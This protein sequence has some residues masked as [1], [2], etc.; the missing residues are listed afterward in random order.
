MDLFYRQLGNGEN[1]TILHGLY[2]SSDN[3]N[4][5]SKL[6]S[7]EFKV[8]ALDLPNHG[9]SPKT[10]NF[11]ISF[12]SKS[13]FEFLKKINISKTHLIG[14]SLGGKIAMNIAYKFPEIVEKLIV[15]DIA[16]RNYLKDE[17]KERENHE[18]IINTLVDIDLSNYRNRSEALENLIKIDKTGRLK[19][20]MM[21]NIS[22]NKNGE[23]EWKINIKAIAD[24]LSQILNKFEINLE[25][26]KKETLFI[27]AENSDYIN[28]NDIELIQNKMQNAKVKIIKDST[29]WV[30]VEKPNE[31]INEIKNFIKN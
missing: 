24:N 12:L 6:L 25:E 26:I 17:F 18:K 13:V 20:F 2:G 8:T 1:I 11:N 10:D 5:I 23:L 31:L 21:K 15:I 29:H 7:D 27:K 28:K 19:M 22:R 14:H 9:K 16:P 30:H 3:W 4:N